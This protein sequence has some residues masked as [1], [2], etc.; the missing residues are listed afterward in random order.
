MIEYEIHMVAICDG[1]KRHI[2]VGTCNRPSDIESIKFQWR[3]KWRLLGI[4]ERARRFG[5]PTIYCQTCADGNPKRKRWHTGL[6][7]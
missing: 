7:R 6:K 3:R 4:M 5:Q 1:C 2:A